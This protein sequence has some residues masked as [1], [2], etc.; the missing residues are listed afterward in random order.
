MSDEASTLVQEYA[1]SVIK[2]DQAVRSGNV[3]EA[4]FQGK[5]TAPIAKRLLRMGDAAK[6]QFASLLYHPYRRVR[7]VSAVHL[8]CAMPDEVLVALEEVA[9]GNDYAAMCAKLRIKEWEEHPE[10][11]DESNWV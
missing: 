6:R 5:R 4:E 9:K 3:K 8:F 10:H 2:Q 7:V 11:Y 1:D